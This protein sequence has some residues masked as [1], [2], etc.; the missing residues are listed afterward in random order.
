MS[1]WRRSAS[2]NKSH[3]N[4]SRQV[5]HFSNFLGTKLKPPS[6]PRPDHALQRTTLVVACCQRV[7]IGRQLLAVCRKQWCLSDE[8]LPWGRSAPTRPPAGYHPG[9]WT[10][11]VR[12]ARGTQAIRC[13]RRRWRVNNTRGW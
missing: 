10:L 6:S 1:P 12:Q 3:E 9:A 8:A 7:N 4:V 11:R 13:P 2:L 5:S